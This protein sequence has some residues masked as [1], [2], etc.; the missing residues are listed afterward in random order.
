MEYNW[1]Q[2]YSESRLGYQFGA[3]RCMGPFSLE[4]AAGVVKRTAKYSLAGTDV[5]GYGDSEYNESLFLGSLGIV[6]PTGNYGLFN[7]GLRTEDFNQWF[8]SIGAGL[9][10]SSDTF[11]GAGGE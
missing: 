9:T 1:H 10:V 11:T 4:A 8:F 6:I 5:N 2:N 3:E 7:L